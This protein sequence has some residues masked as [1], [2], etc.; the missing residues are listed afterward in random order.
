MRNR[1]RDAYRFDD[2]DDDVARDGETV[3]GPMLL[4][5]SADRAGRLTLTDTFKLDRPV[6][7]RDLEL[8]KPGYRT[9]DARKRKPRD[10]DPDEDDDENG[11]GASLEKDA[12]ARTRHGLAGAAAWPL[13]ARGQSERMRQIGVLMTVPAVQFAIRPRRSGAK[14]TQTVEASRAAIE[15]ARTSR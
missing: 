7:I 12:G 6:K 13:A 2:D 15:R 9:I 5:D 1:K 10:D 14:K 8:H 4:M 3:R 11:T